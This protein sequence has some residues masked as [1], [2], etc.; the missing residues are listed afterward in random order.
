LSEEGYATL[1]AGTYN[2]VDTATKPLYDGA[3]TFAAIRSTESPESFSWQVNLEPDQELKLI[4]PTHAEVYYAGGHPA[5]GI[6]AI[7]AHD[8]VGT[9]VPT[10]LAVSGNILTLKVAH[11]GGSFVYPVVG[12]TGWQ[13]GF[14]TYEVAMP[15]P[16]LTQEEKEIF[17]G[18]VAT[19]DSRTRRFASM[20]FGPP[21]ESPS[22]ELPPALQATATGNETKRKYDFNPCFFEPAAQYPEGLNGVGGEEPSTRAYTELNHFCHGFQSEDGYVSI[23]WSAVIHGTAH[24]RLGELVWIKHEPDCDEWGPHKPVLINCYADTGKSTTRINVFGQYRFEPGDYLD[25]T[26]KTCMETNGTL[27]TRPP[28]QEYGGSILRE[29]YH[30]YIRVRPVSDPCPWHNLSS[31]DVAP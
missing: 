7:L 15:P 2:Q 31:T 4:D 18:G 30:R 13:G 1:A 23:R 9:S 17:V 21:V 8:A 19:A 10:T 5:F 12:G 6:A 20:T 16:E 24:Y 29:N 25:T 22:S 26:Q 14:R 28:K 27:G 3:M 11:R